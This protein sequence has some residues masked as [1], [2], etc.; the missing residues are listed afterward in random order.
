[1][2]D[3]ILSLEPLIDVMSSSRLPGE[4]HNSCIISTTEWEIAHCT[5]LELTSPVTVIIQ[6]L[7]IRPTSQSFVP[8]VLTQNKPFGHSNS[9]MLCLCIS[10]L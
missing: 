9:A 4:I 1:M 5:R 3:S 10:I 8:F 2:L 6:I 7:V